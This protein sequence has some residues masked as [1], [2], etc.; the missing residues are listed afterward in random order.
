[1]IVSSHYRPQKKP[2]VFTRGFFR[3]GS[4]SR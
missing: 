2:R 3:S 4:R 1:L